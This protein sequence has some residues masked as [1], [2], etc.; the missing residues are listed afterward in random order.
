MINKKFFFKGYRSIL[1]HDSPAIAVRR[2]AIPVHESCNLVLSDLLASELVAREKDELQ[3]RILLLPFSGLR[4]A[5]LRRASFSRTLRVQTVD[6]TWQQG[7]STILHPASRAS[8]T[9]R[10]RRSTAAA[11]RAAESSMRHDGRADRSSV[12]GKTPR[13]A[14]RRAARPESACRPPQ[15]RG[16][17]SRAASRPAPRSPSDTAPHPWRIG[18]RPNRPSR[19]GQAR[20]G[21]HNSAE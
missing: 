19:T 17:R 4:V 2:K 1:T 10:R 20:A 13:R 8:S 16:E 9:G 15:I 18:R 3:P 21:P 11:P 5:P 12:D 14:T 7:Q 6:V